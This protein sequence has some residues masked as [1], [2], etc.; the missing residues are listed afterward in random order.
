MRQWIDRQKNLLD[1]AL[2]SLWR[3]KGKN[4][5]LVLVYTAIVFLLA[6]V[7]FFTQSLKRE[8]ALLLQGS[9]EIVV[10]RVLAGRHDLIPLAYADRLA[11]L[12]G[13]AQVAGRLWGYYYDDVSRANFTLVVPPD[14]APVPGTLFVGSGVARVRNLSRGSEISIKGHDGTHR[15][16]TVQ[17]V[18]AD[19]SEL[20]TADLI[21]IAAVDFRRLFGAAEGTATD[22]TVAVRNPAEVATV[23]SKIQALLP[24]TRV[25]LRSDILRT[26]DAVFDWRAGVSIVVLVSSLL[27]FVIFAWDKASGLS[28]EERREIGILKAVGWETSDVILLKFWEGAAVTLSSFLAGVLLAYVHVFLTGAPLFA[29]VLKGWSVLY[30][31]FRLVPAVSPYEVATLFF[32]TVVPYTAATIVPSWRVATIDPDAVMRA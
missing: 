30:P 25:I 11:G 23:A 10:Q 19:E 9:P 28:A 8:A 4:V 31:S 24:D 12:R 16:W 22:L 21:L 3:R 20:V 18:F 27:S 7:S 32:L 13:V 29:P 17:G 5:A 1:F 6:S 15:H 14:S 26:Y 2:Q